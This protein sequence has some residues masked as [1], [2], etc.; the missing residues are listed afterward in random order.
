MRCWVQSGRESWSRR[1]IAAV[2]LGDAA[3]VTRGKAKTGTP[4][5][6]PRAPTWSATPAR[7]IESDGVART[8]APG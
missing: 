3:C 6:V 4:V 2:G 1:I 7:S 5:P 8:E